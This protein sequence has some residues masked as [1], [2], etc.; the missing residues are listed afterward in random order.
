M[1]NYLYK[2]KI[3]RSYRID[4][5]N[6][7]LNFSIYN[8]LKENK[9]ELNFNDEIVNY[10]KCKNSIRSPNS[11]IKKNMN[12]DLIKK[13][14]NF[15][16]IYEEFLKSENFKKMI[17]RLKNKQDEEYLKL[18]FRHVKNFINLHK[19]FI[20][21]NIKIIRRLRLRNLNFRK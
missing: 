13:F 4:K 3:Q 19:D 11:D 8:F 1:I 9:E 17:L 7:K 2:N 20:P 12:F 15:K 5:I 18:F 10:F 14:P 6:K 21:S 16:I